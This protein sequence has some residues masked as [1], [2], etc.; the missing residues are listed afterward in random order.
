[1]DSKRVGL[2][3]LALIVLG[4]GV[5]LGV[6]WLSGDAT[7]RTA[8]EAGQVRHVA[9]DARAPPA[10]SD[11]DRA[12]GPLPTGPF[13]AIRDELEVRAGA[14]DAEAAYRLGHVMASCRR[15]EPMADG[16]FAGMLANSGGMLRGAMRI[17]GRPVEEQELFDVFIYAKALSDRTCAG[18]I[19][20][21][22]SVDPGDAHRWIDRAA[23]LGHPQAMAE[24]SQVAFSEFDT[25]HALLDNAGEVARRR[26]RAEVLLDAALRAGE[27]T[28]LAAA[29]SW[30]G[31]DGVRRGDPVRA[32]AYWF[33][34]SRSSEGKALPQAALKLGREQ[35]THGLD[36]AQTQEAEALSHEIATLGLRAGSAQ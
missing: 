12:R 34:Y 24:Y 2:V 10:S 33:A 28:A 8:R 3:L 1:M 22:K 14:G 6:R 19:D 18:A 9:D 13:N 31:P 30:Y 23:A 4:A 21:A 26:D 35:F 25:H 27:P 20:L 5:F 15:Y 29:A 7:S 11:D 16:V 32:L 17:A 36:A